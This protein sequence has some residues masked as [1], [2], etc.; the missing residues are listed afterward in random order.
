MFQLGRRLVLPIIMELEVIEVHVHVAGS[1]GGTRSG[2]ADIHR[3]AVFTL[4]S[5][6]H[7]HFLCLP[8]CLITG[9]WLCTLVLKKAAA[10]S[11]A[12]TCILLK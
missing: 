12:I 1:E 7:N 3:Q 2:L 4:V 8:T 5:S 10:C 6:L 11:A 9:F